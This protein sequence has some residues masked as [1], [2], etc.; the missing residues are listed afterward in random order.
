MRRTIGFVCSVVLGLL[1]G[2]NASTVVY[3]NGGNITDGH[4]PTLGGDISSAM[5][6][7]HKVFPGGNFTMEDIKTNIKKVMPADRVTTSENLW[8]Y[9]LNRTHT[10][11]WVYL[12]DVNRLV[13]LNDIKPGNASKSLGKRQPFC[14]YYTG[15]WA[16]SD[17][18]WWWSAWEASS[19]CMDNQYSGSSSSMCETAS[20]TWSVSE[21]FG[22]SWDK[23]VSALSV[24]MEITFQQ[25]WGFSNTYCCNIAAGSN[26]QLWSQHKIGGA[27]FYG[28]NCWSCSTGGGCDSSTT[29]YYGYA[30]AP[31]SDWNGANTAVGCSSGSNYQCA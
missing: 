11:G 15:Y 20:Y 30:S 10:S 19:P 31:F 2:V 14:S 29:Q 26:G 23:I 3:G 4:P 28:D 24:S 21:N 8:Q 13:D 6:G 27:S 22:L 25:T 5:I 17:A 7:K 12:D 9:V 16:G 1:T 18:T